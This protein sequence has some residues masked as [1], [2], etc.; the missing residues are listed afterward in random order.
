MPAET[1]GTAVRD[2][3]AALTTVPIEICDL[4]PREM[5]LARVAALLA[6][7]APPVSYL[8]NAE[9]AEG[10]T[11]TVDDV[12]GILVA[13]APVIG[14]PRLTAAA[15]NLDL[16]RALGFTIEPRRPDPWR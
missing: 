12:E 4:D 3:D 11:I 1:T 15:R 8:S 6:V 7:N 9:A 2:V 14:I 10:E 16:A 5:T 13:L